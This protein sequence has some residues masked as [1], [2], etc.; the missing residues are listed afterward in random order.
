MQILCLHG[1]HSQVCT[2]V[3]LKIKTKLAT[4]LKIVGENVNVSGT[5]IVRLIYTIYTFDPF[6][7]VII[8]LFFSILPLIEFSS[9]NPVA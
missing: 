3:L 8:L 9:I 4:S 1:E 6:V 5:G 2:T 7:P